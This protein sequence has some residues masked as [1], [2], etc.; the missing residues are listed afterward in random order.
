MMTN[1]GYLGTKN[2][3]H[4]TIVVDDVIMDKTFVFSVICHSQLI[5]CYFIHYKNLDMLNKPFFS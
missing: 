5:L 2:T 4:R 3:E 1:Q